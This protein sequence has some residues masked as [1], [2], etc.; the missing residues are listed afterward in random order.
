MKKIKCI[1][2]KR[3][4]KFIIEDEGGCLYFRCDYCGT[5]AEGFEDSGDFEFNIPKKK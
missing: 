5:S 3:N 1:N 2:C 4:M